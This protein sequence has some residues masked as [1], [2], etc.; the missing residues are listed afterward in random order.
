MPMLREDDSKSD[1]FWFHEDE[2]SR[3]EEQDIERNHRDLGKSS[4][5]GSCR[6]DSLLGRTL[7]DELLVSE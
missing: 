6:R 2:E 5:T 4:D 1:N 3:L 7:S